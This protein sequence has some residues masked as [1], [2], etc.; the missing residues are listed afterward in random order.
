[1]PLEI[2]WGLHAP[3][4]DAESITLAISPG[5]EWLALAFQVVDHVTGRGHKNDLSHVV[6]TDH[7]PLMW[8]PS[9]PLA[10]LPRDQRVIT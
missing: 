6:K 2:C 8:E 5:P 9:D 3:S 10:Q 1:M 7:L 4:G